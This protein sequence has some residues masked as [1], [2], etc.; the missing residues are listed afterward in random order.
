MAPGPGGLVPLQVKLLDLSKP[1]QNGR[2]LRLHC[3]AMRT[4][5]RENRTF[6]ALTA[7]F[8]LREV[9]G[10][11]RVIVHV[12]HEGVVVTK[13][14]WTSRASVEEF[15]RDCNGWI[16]HELT[17][18]EEKLA[19]TL[20]DR[21]LFYGVEHEIRRASVSPVRFSEGVFWAPG[22][23]PQARLKYVHDW[24]RLRAKQALRAAVL[25]WSPELGVTHKRI[26]VRDQV[27]RW[28]SCSEDGAL[29]FNWRLVMAPPEVLEYIVVHE[30]AHIREFDHSRKFWKVVSTHC[31]DYV[32]HEKWLDDHND[33]IMMAGRE[34]AV[35]RSN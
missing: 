25:K 5:L 12:N 3:L 30:L 2:G 19:A 8:K 7:P 17:K 15:L 21:V 33:R 1:L 31:P 16:L 10:A 34:A 20:C 9:R 26:T 35:P 6:G 24:M 32:R 4:L 14:R 22:E 28:G 23:S 18:R 13:P 11:R 29:S 27:S